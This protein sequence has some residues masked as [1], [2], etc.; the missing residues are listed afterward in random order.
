[1][2]NG[3]RYAVDFFMLNMTFV[4]CS[5]PPCPYRILLVRTFQLFIRQDFRNRY[6]NN[7]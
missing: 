3:N 1:M 2:Y 4:M 6:A 7:A 5:C